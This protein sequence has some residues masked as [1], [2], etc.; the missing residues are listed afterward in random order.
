MNKKK[1]PPSDGEIGTNVVAKAHDGNGG[2]Q[3]SD[4]SHYF[5]L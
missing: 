1:Q 5:S 4:V 3:K 2:G